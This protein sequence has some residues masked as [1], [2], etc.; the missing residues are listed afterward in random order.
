MSLRV[1]TANAASGR[2][3]DGTHDHA[4]WVSAAAAVDADV[5]AVQEVD[6]LLPRSGSADQAADL[7]A[8]LGCEVRFAA[9]VHGSPGS[10]EGVVAATGGDPVQASYGVALA[11][12]R[13]VVAWHELHLEPS[14][15]KLPVPTEPGK[16]LWVPDEPRVALAAV[17]DDV[18]VVSTHLSFAPTRAV[19][20]LREVVRWAARL[21]GPTVLLGDLNLPRPVAAVASG[22]TAA[23][24]GATYPSPSPKVQLDHV[25][26]GRGLTITEVATHRLGG[27]D[28]LAVAAHVA[29]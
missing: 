28:H 24:A 8:A 6:R 26:V 10:P 12:R 1:V 17:L 27:S 5:W 7:G 23:A 3:L 20:Q 15:A 4:S 18:T 29:D 2:L 21:P 14:N 25:L 13:P 16:V 11:T 19:K 9:A 22:L